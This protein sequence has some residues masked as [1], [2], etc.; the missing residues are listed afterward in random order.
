[1][2]LIN[3]RFLDTAQTRRDL[4]LGVKTGVTVH[5]LRSDS[6]PVKFFG[7]P[8]LSEFMIVYARI[9]SF[10]QPSLSDFRIN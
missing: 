9:V 8:C 10:A 7:P 5:R 1:M 2:T 4:C 3:P 6:C